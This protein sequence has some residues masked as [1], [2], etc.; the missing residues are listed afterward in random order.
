[1]YCVIQ[2]IDLKKENQYGEHKNIEVYETNWTIKG[3]RGCT[4][5][6]TYSAERFK[7]PIKKAYKIS[8]HHSYREN[9]KVKKKQWV[10]CTMEYYSIA[11]GVTDI[12]EYH[13]LARWE[14][15]LKAIGISEDKL[16]D[17][18]YKKLDPLIEQI[19]SE[20]H[21]TD[22]YKAYKEHR[23]TIEQYKK[24]KRDFESV[25]GDSTYDYCYDVFGEL[26]NKDK[27]E[28]IKQRYKQQQDYQ[29]R[30]YE[31]QYSNHNSYNYSSYQEKSSSTYTD[32]EK[33]FLKKIYK[34]AA[35]KLHPDTSEDSEE[36]MKFLNNLKEQWGI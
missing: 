19:Q 35:L 31:E 32:Q 12:Q 3:V 25:Y 7:R 13:I 36:C 1:M 10:I 30:C 6:Y 14:D 21:K 27:L 15:K 29:R 11:E 4:Y 17:L 34:A 24:A 16:Y 22:E 23:S 26:R 9:G 5:G 33:V 28:E 8:I 20:F 2:K 18:V